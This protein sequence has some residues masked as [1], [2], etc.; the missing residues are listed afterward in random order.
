MAEN[1][2]PATNQAGEVEKLREGRCTCQRFPTHQAN[3]CPLH[4]LEYP[5]DG[6]PHDCASRSVMTEGEAREMLLHNSEDAI[7]QIMRERGFLAALTIQPASLRQADVD[8]A[9]VGREY[10][11]KALLGGWPQVRSP[12]YALAGGFTAMAE[13]IERLRAALATQPATSQEGGA[14]CAQCKGARDDLASGR[15]P[16]E[17][18]DPCYDDAV[19]DL[20]ATPPPTLSEA[21]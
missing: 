2:K 12:Q 1:N 14:V 16:E 7:I 19:A 11:E 21:E 6:M 10:A 8:W 13:E 4:G 15:D 5:F 17:L 3:D 9:D 18:C 20:A